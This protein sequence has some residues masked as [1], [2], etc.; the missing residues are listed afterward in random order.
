MKDVMTEIQLTQTDA[1]VIARQALQQEIS[2]IVSRTLRL[3]NQN[4]LNAEMDSLMIMKELMK[5]LTQKQLKFV[6]TEIT[7]QAMAVKATAK[8]SLM[9][10]NVGLYLEVSPI[11]SLAKMDFGQQLKNVMTS[12]S[13]SFQKD[14]LQ[15][16]K[17]KMDGYVIMAG[18]IKPGLNKLMTTYTPLFVGNQMMANGNQENNVMTEIQQNQDALMLEL[19]KQVIIVMRSMF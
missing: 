11:V 4:A 1:E 19:F 14:A 3:D 7:L 15:V 18:T 13:L 10:I 9:A 6:M 17:L 12:L 2:I 16:V 5:I 8:L